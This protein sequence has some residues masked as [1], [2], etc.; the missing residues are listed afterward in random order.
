MPIYIVHGFRW[1]RH[2]FTGIR[3]HILLNN[4]EDACAEYIQTP[5]SQISILQS[6]RQ[7]WPEI[8][9][10]LDA[11]LVGRPLSFVEQYDPED[12]TGDHSFSQPYAFV[13]D[14]VVE[15]A[16]GAQSLSKSLDLAGKDGRSPTSPRTPR[17]PK[18]AKGVP[19]PSKNSFFK[20]LV[21]P[22]S[23]SVNVEDVVAEGPG[24]TAKGWDALADL[25]DKIATGEKIGWWVVYNGDP[26]RW[27]E[28]SEE[29]EQE[30]DTDEEMEELLQETTLSEQDDEDDKTVTLEDPRPKQKVIPRRPPG[31][32]DMLSDATPP[33]QIK[34]ETGKRKPMAPGQLN[35]LP[36]QKML[37]PVSQSTSYYSVATF[38]RFSSTY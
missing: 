18:S 23:L 3:V 35:I 9:A 19:T 11:S 22:Q 27:Y 14:R 25:R 21:N 33:T 5:D 13:A 4:L 24:L 15:L 16:V 2:G 31:A 17:T 7:K 30:Y 12:E 26:E 28:G 36:Q 1:P 10:E 38:L 37:P 6:F 29:A 34:R 20:A 32:P 8:M